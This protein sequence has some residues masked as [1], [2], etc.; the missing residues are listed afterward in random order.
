MRAAS[1]A[2]LFCCFATVAAL[3]RATPAPPGARAYFLN[4]ADGATVSSPFK[5]VFGLSGMG[6]APAGCA[7]PNTGHHHLL[8]DH[9]PLDRGEHGASW[10]S[11]PIPAD[12]S[13]LH[14]GGGQTETMLE[15][16]P[17]RHSLQLLLGD[18]LHMPHAPPVLSEAITLTVR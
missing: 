15:L 14:F 8:I 11:A 18:H 10:M 7:L 17:G 5:V 1:L 9:S 3:A 13:H 16:P 6:V 4:L 12:D 2:A